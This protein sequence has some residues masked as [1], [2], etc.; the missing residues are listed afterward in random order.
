M[1]QQSRRVSHEIVDLVSRRER[2]DRV[3]GVADDHHRGA[4][5]G[6][7]IKTRTKKKVSL[8]ER[9]KER[10]EARQVAH[11]P[12]SR[13]SETFGMLSSRPVFAAGSKGSERE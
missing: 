13:E 6:L 8:D 1:D 5:S 10:E 11:V 9:R 7:K 12:R 3:G 2:G 4:K